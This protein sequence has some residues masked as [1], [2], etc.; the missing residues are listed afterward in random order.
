VKLLR[1][2]PDDRPALQERLAAF[3]RHISYPLG[4]DRFT[5]DHG[6]DYYAF[7]DRLGQVSASVFLD[8]GG[9]LIG[10]GAA[11]LRRVPFVAGDAPR[12]AWY[13]C[14]VKLHPDHRGQGIGIAG[15]GR[16]FLSHYLRCGRGYAISMNPGDG[17]ANGVVRH[18]RRF[19]RARIEVAGELAIYSLDADAMLRLAPLLVRHRGPLSYLSLAGKKDLILASSGAR[20]PL[21]HVQFGPC[22]ELGLPA[23][24]AGHAHMFCAM[25]DSALAAELAAD[26]VAEA[27]SATII[28]HRMK[29]CDWQFV[30]TSDI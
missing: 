16:M 9:G 19:R 20:M 14:D 27:A 12:K 21:L 7:F 15:A 28:A 11:I 24:V 6:G 2:R 30:L 25:R 5:L 13:T 8:D 4:A 22:A 23:P 26:G 1:V 10:T 29:P 18:A 17:S 3:D